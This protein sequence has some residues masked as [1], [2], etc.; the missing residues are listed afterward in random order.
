MTDRAILFTNARVVDPASRFDGPGQV[1]VRDG[2]IVAVGAVLGEPPEGTLVEDC[3]GHALM[4]GLIDMRVST[5]EPGAEHRETLKSAGR[6][7]VFGGVTSMVVQPD[8]DPVIDDGSLVDFIARRGR[9][10][11]AARVLPAGALTKGMK[12]VRMA[13]LGLMAEAGAVM[14]CNGRAP[15]ADSR[16]LA[17]ALSYASAFDALVATRPEDP[18][19]AEGGVMNQGELAARLGLAGIPHAA[20]TIAAERDIQ[21]AGLTGGRLLLDMVSAEGTLE[22]LAR[23]R[24]AGIEVS[25]SVTVQHLTLNET[26]VGDYRTF[27]KLSPPLRRED[28]RLALIEAVRSGLIEAVVSD[29]DPRPAEEKRLPFDEAAFGASGLESLLPAALTLYHEGQ[30]ELLDIMRPLTIGPA[31][32]LGLPQGRIAAGAPADLIQ[33]DLGFPLRFDAARMVSKSK[34]S[35][36]DGR[37]LQGRVLQ[38]WVAGKAVFNVALGQPWLADEAGHVASGPRVA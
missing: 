24:A 1:L 33:V 17:R 31:S 18:W 15:I 25:A 10:R 23:A 7:A 14:F 28:D 4:P 36:Y 37:R 9:D 30:I 3:D 11:S 26:D 22:R 2:V 16:V 13:E 27:A 5:G 12:G 29:H 38:T 34:N 8:C 6:A 19:L 35:P 20:E 21:L 32:L